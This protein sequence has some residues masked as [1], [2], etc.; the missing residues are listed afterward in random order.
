M[1]KIS[2]ENT[3]EDLFDNLLSNNIDKKLMK[4]IINNKSSED[5]IEE[6]VKDM[7]EK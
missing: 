1:V 7:G 6:I 4:L 5:I 2:K 3:I